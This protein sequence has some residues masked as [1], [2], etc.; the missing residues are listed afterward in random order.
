MLFSSFGVSGPL[1]VDNWNY[2]PS[3]APKHGKKVAQTAKNAGR[4]IFFIDRTEKLT[5]FFERRNCMR[6]VCCTKMHEIRIKSEKYAAR[7]EAV[8]ARKQRISTGEIF[9]K[10]CECNEIA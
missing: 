8:F 6:D 7:G 1:P 2:K 9:E 4:S 5:G 10:P 3:A